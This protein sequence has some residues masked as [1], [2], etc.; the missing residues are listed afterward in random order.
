MHSAGCGRRL[1][2]HL[3]LSAPVLSLAAQAPS[4]QAATSDRGDPVS[5]QTLLEAQARALGGQSR[6]D[7]L[8]ALE[9][10]GSRAHVGYLRRFIWMV[11]A[12]T[13]FREDLHGSDLDSSSGFGPALG[14]AQLPN[15]VV[16]EQPAQELYGLQLFRLVSSFAWLNPDLLKLRTGRPIF[17]EDEGLW[18]ISYDGPLGFSAVL[19]F[20]PRT[21]LLRK[22]ITTDAGVRLTLEVS[23]FRRV[24]GVLVP[25]FYQLIQEHGP[26]RDITSYQVEKVL[27]GKAFTA[28]TFRAPPQPIPMAFPPNVS[29]VELPTRLHADTGY[30][31]VQLEL[32]GEEHPSWFVLDSGAD[33]SVLDRSVLE[34]YANLPVLEQVLMGD[35]GSTTSHPVVP[36]GPF[37]LGSAET[38]QVTLER[39]T[40]PLMDLSGISARV[41]VPVAGILG[42]ELF[43]RCVVRIDFATGKV[44]LEPTDSFQSPDGAVNLAM[45]SQRRV[46]VGLQQADGPR[47]DRPFL[48]D[49]GSNLT[50]SMSSELAWR[51]RLEPPEA[52]RL[53]VMVGG[54]GAQT[55]AYQGR[56]AQVHMGG[57]ELLGPVATF[58]RRPVP[59]PGSSLE[60]G[61]LGTPVLRRFKMDFDLPRRQVWLSPASDLNAPFSYNRS[62]LFIKQ[63]GALVVTGVRE[64]LNLPVS[65]GDRIVG[66]RPIADV[67]PEAWVRKPEEVLKAFA[68]PAG[69]RLRVEVTRE[70]VSREFELGL[71]DWL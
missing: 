35:E 15:G 68:G 45:D 21:N 36:L 70:G 37:S 7:R 67:R 19:Y 44:A 62:G 23:D 17:R 55:N 31:L 53:P 26:V 66:V 41:G 10:V 34:R 29:R 30:L 9:L 65:K 2:L 54:V 4:A 39:M 43:A 8:G 1:W 20:D 42:A 25:H 28:E 14:Y 12:D 32:P 51:L 5:V 40:L 57:F 16:L 13:G 52:Q 64:G 69:S 56:I 6:I 50:L 60:G 58:E 24:K 18:R 71:E 48:L 22:A 63:E 59:P 49:T 27:T 3:L 46:L 11:K 61:I 47:Q 38:G 33:V